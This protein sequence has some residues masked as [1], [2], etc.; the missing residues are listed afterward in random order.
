MDEQ[1]LDTS[2]SNLILQGNKTQQKVW[3]KKIQKDLD[4]LQQDR[5][6]RRAIYRKRKDFFRGDQGDYSNVNGIVKD[7]KLKKGHTNQVA[8]YA[9]KT[10]VKM[11]FGIANNPPK[12]T[13]PP[14]D[15]NDN[16]EAIRA[17]AVEDFQDSVF[18]SRRNK[19]W[20]KTYRRSA[21]IQAELGDAA[22]KTY[23]DPATKEIVICGH[24][25]METVS[26]AWSGETGVFDAVIVE[27]ELTPSRVEELYGIKVNPKA[28]KSPTADDT[29]SA[30]SWLNNGQ[31]ATKTGQAG[32][33]LPTGKNRLPKVRVVEYDSADVYAI[34]IENELVQLIV[35]DDIQYPKLKI[36]TIIPNIPNPPSPWSIA[37]ID[38][39]I[40]VQVELNENDNRTADHLRVGNVQRYVAYNL[41][42]FDPESL[43]TSSGQVIFVDDPE[44]KARF[45][46]LQTNVN[47]FPDD[48]YNSRK[49]QQMYDMGL[50]RV[51][52]GSISGASSGRSQA[53][54]YQ[55]S[56]DL[57]EFKRDS[58]ELSLQDIC[59]K[60][61]IL[62]NYLHG[63]KVDWFKDSNG[64][65]I[66]RNV[67]F[68]W[69]DILPTSSSDKIVNVANKF[70]MI[71]LPLSE[72]FKELGYRNPD[73]MVEKLKKELADPLLMTLRAKAWQLSQ[74][75][76]EAT[77]NAR[78]MEQSN[79]S[80]GPQANVSVSVKADAATQE[81][82]QILNDVGIQATAPTQPSGVQTPNVGGGNQPSPVLTPT[83]NS[84]TSKPMASKGGTTTYSSAV[85]L[86]NRTRQNQQAG[87]K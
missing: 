39:L 76:L 80:Q 30:G 12:L 53:I 51:N 48:Q 78:T 77:N 56:I 47:N 86:I 32:D 27:L 34:K 26:V 71:G 54:D 69:T 74:G 73:A 31:W 64:N 62:G 72:A 46:P 45:E 21:F 17:Q 16:T 3:S 70:N 13:L 38:Y 79:Q 42:D 65:F 81:G 19:F 4:D 28:L 2:N 22:I 50:P 9:G 59:E 49:L 7:T 68:D 40:D 37:D 14:Q 35:K 82:Q 55:S 5:Q 57:T 52:Y 36:W 75:L 25:D 20:K 85:G 1:L 43:K 8:N 24:D 66:V 23:L 87:G 15:I 6:D 63:D 60:I 58:W 61:Q 11:A 10:T 18:N 83:Q 41:A 67:E 84:G 33:G 44:G 29:S